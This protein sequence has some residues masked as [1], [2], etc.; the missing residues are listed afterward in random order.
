MSVLQD[1]LAV[2]EIDAFGG[3]LVALVGV[4]L[5]L[6]GRASHRF[7]RRLLVCFGCH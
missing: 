4:L 5:L 1:D 2:E 6:V 3:V 7:C